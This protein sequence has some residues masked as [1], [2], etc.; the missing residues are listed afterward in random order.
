MLDKELSSGEAEALKKQREAH[1]KRWAFLRRPPGFFD[2]IRPL[3]EPPGKLVEAYVRSGQ[4]VADLACAGG[5]YTF[6][7]ADRVGPEGKVYAI[8]LGEDCIRKINAKAKKK[9]YQNIDAIAASAADLASIP[10]KSVDFVFANGLL[11]SMENDRPAAVEEIKRVL[12][13]TG[14][15]FISLGE[16]PPWGLV[17]AAEWEEIL[18]GFSVEEGGSFEQRW[19]F[20]SLKPESV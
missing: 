1:A 18:S 7:L 4:V 13:P 12:K 20:V 6:P 2:F 10:S 15:A 9:G 5:Y 11:C 19:A 8:D 14:K 17:D 3:F 16:R